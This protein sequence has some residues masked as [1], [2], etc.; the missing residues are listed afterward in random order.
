MFTLRRKNKSSIPSATLP[1][2]PKQYYIQN[3]ADGVDD[4]K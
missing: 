2:G 3:V 4:T 1:W